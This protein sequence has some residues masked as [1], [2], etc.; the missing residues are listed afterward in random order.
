MSDKH[1]MILFGVTDYNFYK[2]IDGK[3]KDEFIKITTVKTVVQN[4][5]K[6]KI[7]ITLYDCTLLKANGYQINTM[8]PIMMEDSFDQGDIFPGARVES[9]W[10]FHQN[11][12]TSVKIQDKFILSTSLGDYE[13]IVEKKAG[14]WLSGLFGSN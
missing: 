5:D 3:R 14:G 7:S 9:E 13:Y 12:L 1:S 2:T 6:E 11:Q 4:I 10:C 8:R